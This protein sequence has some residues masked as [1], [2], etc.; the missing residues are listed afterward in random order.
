MVTDDDVREMLRS[1]AAEARVSP[2][3]WDSIAA[4][5]AEAERPGPW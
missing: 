4:R 5:I 3:A 2:D 1:R